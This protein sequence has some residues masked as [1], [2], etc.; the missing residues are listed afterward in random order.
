MPPISPHI[1]LSGTA[2][3]DGGTGLRNQQAG[4]ITISGVVGSPTGAIVYWAVQTSGPVPLSGCSSSPVTCIKIGKL[5]P[6][7]A[8][9]VVIPGT[10]VGSGGGPCWFTPGE[11]SGTIT[12]FAAAVPLSVATGNGTYLVSLLPG[13]TGSTAGEN[14]WAGGPAPWAEGA[15]LVIFYPGAGTTALYDVGLAGTSFLTV[16][17][18][19][20]KL[21]LPSA[22][23]GTVTLFDE[24]GADGQHDVGRLALTTVSNE[25]TKI[26]GVAVAGPGSAAVDGDWNG[27]DS[28]P[29][30]QL[31][32]TAGH[33]ISAA[34]PA[35][36]TSLT[37]KI[38]GTT[39]PV[40][41]LTTVANLVY[42][43]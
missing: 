16:P 8:G 14:P 27:G 30:P 33:D 6:V 5:A 3:Q 26:N 35:G 19:T 43:A 4:G 29:L 10:V 25:V 1:V 13:S 23:P 18:L 22:T 7:P 41:C 2:Y 39:T 28:T 9:P 38:A 40:D 42:E 17:G 31:W 34:I 32:D 15:S 36:T 11:L 12:V 20:Y 37:V 24:I 21:A